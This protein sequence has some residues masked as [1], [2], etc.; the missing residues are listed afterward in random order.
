MI[1]HL[2]TAWHLAGDYSESDKVCLRFRDAYPKSV[3]LPAVLFRHA[4]NAYFRALAAE[5]LPNAAERHA[6]PRAGTTRRS[7]A[8][9]SSSRSIRN[10]PHVNLARYG[11]GMAHYRK[12]DLDKAKE[13]L[14][15]IPA[16]ERNGDLAL[17]SYQL[18]DILIRQAPAK[19]DD[20]LAAG[21]LEEQLKAAIELLE[22]F[23]GAQP[24]GP[25][26]AD[27]LFKLGHC[28][29]R[30]AA[31]L[32]QPPD[33]AKALAAA[34]AAYEQLLQRFPKDP[35]PT[36]SAV[37]E[38]AKVLA[39]AKDI[40]GAI[41]ELRRFLND[42]LKNA[43][44]APMAVLHLATLLRGQNNPAEAAKVL[45]QCR[46]QHE[47][48]LHKDPARAGWV[49]LLQYHQGVALREAG[50]RP[51]SEGSPRS[52]R[53]AVERAAPKRPKPLCGRA[54]A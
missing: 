31:L 16:A 53:H 27:A 32:A 6:K 45:A 21:K 39:R 50:K 42:P 24:N 43:P 41:N 14:G 54:S 20:A 13:T 38:R 18:A 25:Q 40:N 44:V 47:Q 33:Q 3:L 5:K 26:T 15:A 34:R 23:V 8:I 52:G 30:L 1:Q 48:D 2:A 4:E 51:G 49:P 10:S 19:A 12:G 7:S 9:R 36:P 11:L 37:F 35:H 46:Q 17:V 29:Q 22:G 28:Q